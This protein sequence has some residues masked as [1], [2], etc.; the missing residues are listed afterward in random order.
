MW[1]LCG[2]AKPLF[3]CFRSVMLLMWMISD[4]SQGFCFWVT[5][6]NNSIDF[7]FRSQHLKV[8]KCIAKSDVLVIGYTNKKKLESQ[9]RGYKKRARNSFF[10]KTLP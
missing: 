1:D 6:T 7:K 9:F 5:E 10:Q 2:K 8:Q 4:V 3:C